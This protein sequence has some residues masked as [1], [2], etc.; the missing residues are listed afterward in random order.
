MAIE[1]QY[2]KFR[3]RRVNART[4]GEGTAVT[5]RCHVRTDADNPF[6]LANQYFIKLRVRGTEEWEIAE[7]A[8]INFTVRS[9]GLHTGTM[10]EVIS[11]SALDNDLGEEIART[12]SFPHLHLTPEAPI[13]NPAGHLES[14]SQ[15]NFTT[16]TK[17]PED[18]SINPCQDD[19]LPEPGSIP[20]PPIEE[21][22]DYIPW[23]N[24]LMLEEVESFERAT[25]FWGCEEDT[26]EYE[27][28]S[29]DDGYEINPKA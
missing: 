7:P 27:S 23:L 16:K 14:A 15:P 11:V 1:A 10:Y 17:K 26:W 25:E 22:E 8:E 9:D 4:D 18:L 6:P 19:L 13:Q 24:A 2:M 20:P 28:W 29:D 5:F 21:D 3:H 12:E